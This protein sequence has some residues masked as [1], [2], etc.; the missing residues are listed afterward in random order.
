MGFVV[1]H[2]DHIT[3]KLL[4]F[5]RGK[6]DAPVKRRGKPEPEVFGPLGTGPLEIFNVLS[7]KGEH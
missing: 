1:A 3:A 2:K 4:L 6:F 7:S 5:L